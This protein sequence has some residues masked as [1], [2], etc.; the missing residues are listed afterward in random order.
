MA[1]IVVHV[2]T[3]EQWDSV[4]DVWF[5][6]GYSWFSGLQDYGHDKFNDEYFRGGE[7]RYLL[8]DKDNDILTPSFLSRNI[9]E[10]SDFMAQQKEDNK[11]E[12]YYVTQGKLNVIEKLKSMSFP[13]YQLLNED[14]FHSLSRSLD[15]NTEKALL[16]YIGGDETIEFKVKE[17]LYRLLR[18][19]DLGDTVYMRIDG[20]GTPGYTTSKDNCFTAPLEEIKKWETPAWEIEK[21]K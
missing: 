10:Y 13:L 5:K 7:A 19:D 8:L 16:R 4:L 12:T 14:E 15:D 3:L 1:E 2:T 21:V 9:I 11:M 17:Q 20:Y 18:I 6:Q